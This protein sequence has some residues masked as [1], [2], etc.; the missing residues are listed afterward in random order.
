MAFAAWRAR[1]LTPAG[2]LAAWTVGVLVLRGTGWQG[3]AVLAAFFISSNLVSRVGP[4]STP[5]GLDP[6][7]DRRDPWQVY[8]NGGAA[9]LGAG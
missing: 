3:G 6:K 9:A 1:T 7:P 4:R 5:A 8:A 2:A